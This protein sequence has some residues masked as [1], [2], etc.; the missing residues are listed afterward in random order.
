M[1][2][3]FFPT[4]FTGSLILPERDPS[5][6][7]AVWFE[8]GAENDGLYYTFPAG[9]LAGFNYLTADLMLDGNELAVF[10]LILQEGENGPAF[11]C[12]FGLLNQCSARMRL[13]LEAVNQN[14]WMYDREGAWLKPLCWGDRVDLAKVDRMG[15]SL[16]RKGPNPVQFLPLTHHR[17]RPK[18][19]RAWS[20]LFLPKGA[21]L[22]ELGQ[23]A[24]REWPTKT[25]SVEK[26]TARLHA[27]L[28]AAA[29]QRL[30]EGL[31]RWGGWRS[32]RCDATGFFRVQRDGG[33]WWLV[34][35]DGYRFWSAGVDC[36][37]VDTDANFG[38]L[39][40]RAGLAARP[41]GRVRRDLYAS[42]EGTPHDQLPGRQ[43]DPR[44]WA[45]GLVREMGRNHPGRAAPASGSTPS[46][47]GRI[48]KSPARRACPTCARWIAS[49]RSS[50]PAIYRD[51]PDVFHP[52]F[53]DV[54]EA[55]C[56]TAARN[57]RRPG[58]DRLFPDER[59]HLG[60]CRRDLPPRGCSSTR[61]P[62]TRGAPWRTSCASA[63]PTMTA[64]AAAWGLPATLS[65][66]WLR[67]SG[68]CRSAGLPRAATWPNSAPSWSNASS[69]ARA[70]ACR[71]VDPN[72]LN[73]GIRYYTV[74][75]AWAL[76]G[77]RHFDVF[78]MN[79]YKQPPARR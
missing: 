75:P 72:H 52:D 7:D 49:L 26:L 32:C 35:P 62:A 22:D 1:E 78:S 67:A 79:C 70:Q 43:P 57:A 59:A 12:S 65:A 47:T 55:V 17:R 73:L 34:D 30:P 74:P 18:N 3:P 19:P 41:A 63:T 76:D 60:L 51:F 71:R 31:S 56:R 45:A 40:T 54:V 44:L 14:R 36:V 20:S 38:G 27:Q 9:M 77:M 29:E 24:L 58:L 6:P 16:M 2:H 39:E 4:R 69:A 15:F 13:P 21:L 48:G 68:A 53:P 37:S 46:A 28:E 50:L 61:P 11:R 64:L 66:C 8:A 33:R 23:S 25:R 5:L 10:V 42:H